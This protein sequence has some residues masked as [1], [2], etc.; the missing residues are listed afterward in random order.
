[1]SNAIDLETGSRRMVKTFLACCWF[2]SLTH[3]SAQL[4]LVRAKPGASNRRPKRRGPGKPIPAA[5]QLCSAISS[6]RQP[7]TA[8]QPVGSRRWIAAFFFLVERAQQCQ[9][10]GLQ[11]IRGDQDGV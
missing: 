11:V 3:G 7:L 10:R 6:K 8:P 2:L 4:G 1:M 9:Y 5:E